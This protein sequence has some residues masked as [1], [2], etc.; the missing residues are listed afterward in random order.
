MK[1]SNPVYPICVF[2]Q[3]PKVLHQDQNVAW[4][5]GICRHSNAWSRRCKC[6]KYIDPVK[7]VPV[8]MR[9][10]EI[11]SKTNPIADLWQAEWGPLPEVDAWDLAER[12]LASQGTVSE[13]LRG[14][15]RDGT[16]YTVILVDGRPI[17]LDVN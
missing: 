3:H 17:Y 16:I 7:P 10:Q 9:Y 14:L 11:K 12:V 6:T 2:C 1:T 15:A 5:R 8:E 4:S 13:K